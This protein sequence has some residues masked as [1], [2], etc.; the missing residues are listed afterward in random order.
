MEI[1]PMINEALI[2]SLNLI[3]ESIASVRNINSSGVVDYHA[4]A[5]LVIGVGL[6]A[7]MFFMYRAHA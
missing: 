6:V 4:G 5:I 3:R 7:M 2:S 1:Q